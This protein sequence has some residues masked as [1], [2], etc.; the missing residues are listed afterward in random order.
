[1]EISKKKHDKHYE[2]YLKL[3][4]IISKQE[5]NLNQCISLTNTET[6]CCSNNKSKSGDTSRA[7]I[8][9]IHACSNYLTNINRSI[10][11]QKHTGR[12]LQNLDSKVTLRLG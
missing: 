7:V 11:N 3:K 1:M 6:S 8:Q 4:N 10:K 2:D 9:R 12:F 5:N